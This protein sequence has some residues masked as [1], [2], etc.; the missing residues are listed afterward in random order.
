MPTDSENRRQVPPE[1]RN[2]PVR[3]ENP[4]RGRLHRT[5]FNLLLWRHLARDDDGADPIGIDIAFLTPYL[6]IRGR[7]ET[8][9]ALACEKLAQSVLK[10]GPVDADGESPVGFCTLLSQAWCRDGVLHYSFP[11]RL[12]ALLREP[13]GLGLMRLDL[14][15]LFRGRHTRALYGLLSTLAEVETRGWWDLDEF[16]RLAG[17]D[18]GLPF[19]D[20]RR[21]VVEPALEEINAL[22]DLNAV[23]EYR[24]SGRRVT[25][26]KFRVTRK[27]DPLFG[28]CLHLP[29]AGSGK[30]DRAQALEQ[31]FEAY[32]A[33][34]VCEVTSRMSARQ[35]RELE[36][37]FV[38]SIEGNRVLMK[39]FEQDG[40]DSLSV[41]LRYEAFLEKML[42]SG[43]QTDF[44][45]FLERTG[46]AGE[47]GRGKGAI[48]KG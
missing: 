8:Q 46:R 25:G 38:R 16:R 39:K 31:E 28:Q 3:L 18:A 17:Q 2:G 13:G 21:R 45:R 12:K 42:L 32:K 15:D 43:E 10:W 37:A 48:G 34:R 1:R 29:G 33:A 20:L 36:E 47:G 14:P 11:S 40:F 41:R 26:I 6:D 9:L 23:V 5:L 30:L 44:E 7:V 27:N 22:S 35:V 4:P 24:R 19:S